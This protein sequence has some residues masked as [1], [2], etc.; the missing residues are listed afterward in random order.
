MKNNTLIMLALAGF[1]LYLW[2]KSDKG[3]GGDGI[4]GLLGGEKEQATATRPAPAPASTSEPPKIQN[5]PE[6]R[7]GS[8]NFS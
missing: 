4:A 3:R 6:T 8:L 7:T 5:I 2:D 1:G